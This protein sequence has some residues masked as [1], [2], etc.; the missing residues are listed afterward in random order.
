M[1]EPI[2][3]VGRDLDIEKRLVDTAGEGGMEN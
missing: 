3:R 1:F 2:C